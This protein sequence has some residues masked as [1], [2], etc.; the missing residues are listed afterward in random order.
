M[1]ETPQVTYE[2]DPNVEPADADAILSGLAEILA[3]SVMG[4]TQ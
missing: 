1:V 2:T 3:D 4:E